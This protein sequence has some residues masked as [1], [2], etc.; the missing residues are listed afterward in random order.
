MSSKS[1]NDFSSY[2]H[3][4]KDPN[5]WVALALDKSLP[6]QKEAKEALLR[7]QKTWCRQFVLPVIRPFARLFIVIVQILRIPFPKY[8]Q[9]S[10][11]LHG[12]IRWGMK[13]FLKKDA[14]YLILRHFNIGS[15]ILQFIAANVPNVKMDSHPLH[16]KT[17]DD[18]RDNIF[19]QHDL[20]I[21]NF[22]T[23]LSAQLAEA[24]K[25]I[26]P[27]KK[28][29]FEAI[30]DAAVDYDNLKESKAAFLD[31]Q[32]AIELYTPMFALL[33]SDKDFWRA[34]HSLQL[35]ETIAIYVA[36]IFNDPLPLTLVNN[37]HPLVPHSTLESGF[38]LMLHGLDAENLYGY[39]L[40]KKAEA[41]KSK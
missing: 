40:Q 31:V 39:I 7:S 10:R 11:A 37:R 4:P 5:P 3:D 9:S 25:D 32:T 13:R 17:P 24:E 22:V 19:V 12:I 8:P 29:N 14:N 38:R 33:L 16:P 27:A 41:E 21:F 28:I 18:I 36:K 20:N 2:I 35:D 6:L 1:K 15:Q 26:V 30:N 23:Q 34:S